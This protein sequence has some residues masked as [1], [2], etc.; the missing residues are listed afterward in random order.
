MTH[1]EQLRAAWREANDLVRAA[2]DRLG[3]AWTA[4]ARG[5]A[6]PPD[7]DLMAEVSR[8]RR[9]CDQRLSVLLDEF[10]GDNQSQ[11]AGPGSLPPGPS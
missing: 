3:D 9:E 11:L 4:F 7:P 1:Y 6:G 5:K 8:L 2:E 10:N